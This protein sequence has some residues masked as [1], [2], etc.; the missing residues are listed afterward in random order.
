[1]EMND[2]VAIACDKYFPVT[3]KIKMIIMLITEKVR[4]APNAL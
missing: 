4:T 3:A 1:M 2:A